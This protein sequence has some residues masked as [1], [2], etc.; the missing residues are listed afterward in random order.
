MLSS[1]SPVSIKQLSYSCTRNVKFQATPTVKRGQTDV[2]SVNKRIYLGTQMQ[3]KSST[4]TGNMHGT[5]S[6]H[7]QRTEK[8][9]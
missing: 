5:F 6:S 3:G 7:N 4:V 8:D 2:E 1:G 9:P